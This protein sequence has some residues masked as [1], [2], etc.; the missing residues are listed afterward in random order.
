MKKKMIVMASFATILGLTFYSACNTQID[1]R[2][3]KKDEEKTYIVTVGGDVMKDDA[4]TLKTYRNRVISQLT[5]ELPADSF[6]ITDTYDTVM[7]GFAIKVNSTYSKVIENING[8]KE[9]CMSHTYAIPETTSS[10]LVASDAGAPFMTERL[11]N[12]SAETMGATAADIA[13]AG[14]KAGVTATSNGG[15]NVT[16]GI[17]DTGMYLNQIAGSPSR[18]TDEAKYKLNPAAF[19]DIKDGFKMTDADVQSKGFSA[20]YYTRF[21]NKIF[22]ARDYAGSDN[23]VDPT[24]N[25]SEHG[26]H[27][28]SL[29]GANGSVFKGIA[30]NA[31]IAVM[32]VFGD[33]QGGAATNAIISAVEDAAKLGLD[34]INLSLG[35]DLV[36][37]DDSVD[38]PT[39]KALKGAMDK[40]VIVNFAAGNAGKSSFSSSRTYS[41]WTTDIVETGILGGDAHF[42]ETANIIAASNPDKAFFSSILTVK[43]DGA[44][45]S[46]AVSYSDQ[47]VPSSTQGTLPS[48]PL[49]GL[50]PEGQTQTSV[51]Y[52][53]IPN[54]GKSADYE[55]LDVNGKIAVVNRGTSTFVQKVKQAANHGAKA[56]ICINNDPSVTFNFNMAFEDYDPPIPVVFVFQ[57]TKS[58][59]GAAK[60]T[61]TLTIGTNTV[62]LAS[63][64]NTIASFSSDGGDYNL[65]LGVTITAPGK[66]I[67]GAVNATYYNDNSD[68]TKPGYSLLTGY[69]NMSGTSMAAPNLTG[70]MALYLGEKNPVNNGAF[71]VADAAAYATEKNVM[72]MK[73]MAAADQL[74]DTTGAGT[75][76]SPRV[77]GAGRIN[78][79][80]MLTSNS[81][82]TT[83]NSDLGGFSNTTEA[84]AEI[85]NNGSLKVANGDFS[86]AGEAY[87]EFDYTVHNDSTT[88]KTYTPSLS[89][90]IPSLRVNTTHDEYKEETEDS[91]SETIGYDKD[92]YFDEND[93]S[94]YPYG[95]G[96]VTASVNDDLLE[97]P[98]DHM[99][100]SAVSVP[101]NSSA[102]A[103]IKVRIDDLHIEKNWGDSMVDNF[104]GT[105]K[106]YFG[107][108]FAKAGGNYVE[109]YLTLTEAGSDRD[110][111][112]SM[113]YLGFYGDYTKG[114]AVED[115]DFEREDRRL[116]TSD[117]INNYM[118]N[119]GNDQ[120]KKSDAY[121]GSTLSAR[122]SS[123]SQAMLNQLGNMSIS[124][125]ANGMEFLSVTGE[126][127]NHVYAGA[128]GISDHLIS[129]FFVNRA[130]DKATWTV[131]AKNGS[132]VKS[133]S[134]QDLYVYGDNFYAQ[135]TDLA[136]SWMVNTTSTLAPFAIHRGYADIDLSKVAEGEYTLEY[137]FTPKGTGVAQVKSYPLTVDKTAP[138]VSSVSLRKDGEDTA[139]DVVAKGASATITADITLSRATEKVEGSDD[140]YSTW[141]WMN[142]KWIDNDRVLLELTDYAHNSTKV[143][144]KPSMIDFSVSSTFFTNRN[145]F[146][147]SLISSKN[148]KYTYTVAITD[149]ATGNDITPKGDYYVTVAVAKGLDPESIIVNVDGEQ[150]DTVYDATTG[151]LTI[152]LSK[153]AG[154]FDINVK[155]AS[156]TDPKP[157]PQ[158][159]PDPEP[160]KKGCSGSVI[161]ASSTLGALAL[162]A[163]A[164][165]VKKKKE[166]K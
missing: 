133:G 68:A 74:V 4:K 89:V 11:T 145:D 142:Q 138:T 56:M 99:N 19:V 112:L 58:F 42:D 123:L 44:D 129:V 76:A 150:I 31:Q 78:V 151:T 83:V 163:T 148:G 141:F 149:T 21:N 104:S 166:Q 29:T 161:A 72:S 77:Q 96:Q 27:V 14:N 137:S 2:I 57:N 100:V 113:P 61:G 159:T 16:V 164:I 98:A 118:Q 108:Y 114:E 53:V 125:Q 92:A 33:D 32:K 81:Y 124:A 59:F 71:K 34:I 130:I 50:I 80:K 82:V 12:Y 84:V 146:M 143:I 3:G 20:N 62:Q 67:M 47:A 79:R 128:P 140:L 90:M 22:F 106:E 134:V 36:T 160:E 41:D 154:S 107:K 152:K 25:G 6:E 43:P 165:A 95:V 55:G 139:L 26:T 103:K 9:V 87:V 30:P 156:Q 70:A 155:T 17:I 60:S 132:T 109:G 54:F 23:D 135:E 39:Y 97:I 49:A 153:D 121:T 63:D 35:T 88:A 65:D 28:A 117:L 51:D 18:L 40:G 10:P 91:R 52:V 13:A 64:G 136:K 111:D 122:S 45:T 162:L 119:L 105:L 8:V 75:D 144:V 115:F 15:K 158:P 38:N 127:K 5:Y 147:I 66:E 73:A 131:K 85:K 7:N 46:H 157:N 94:T 24:K 110:E 101:A 1:D 48:R 86:T 102:K 69:E 120:Y 93:A 126:E 37:A 116:Y